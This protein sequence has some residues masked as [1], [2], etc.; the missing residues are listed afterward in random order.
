MKKT[1]TLIELLVVIAII[2]ILAGMLLPA[3][4]KAR[5]KAKYTNCLSNTRQL[6]IGVQLYAGDYDDYILPACAPTSWVSNIFEYVKDPKTYA[7]YANTINITRGSSSPAYNITDTLYNKGLTRRNYCIN[8]HSGY[9]YTDGRVQYNLKKMSSMR[10]L[11]RNF[12]IFCFS[13][14]KGDNPNKGYIQRYYFK[15]SSRKSEP[16]NCPEPVHG[17]NFVITYS[18]GHSGSVAVSE[19]DAAM[20]NIDF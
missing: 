4:G 16:E 17:K 1:F 5:D 7:C 19:M 2:A 18:D 11:S 15:S 14:T 8:M 13:Y 10:Y 9:L 12:L 3:L 6:G 20:E